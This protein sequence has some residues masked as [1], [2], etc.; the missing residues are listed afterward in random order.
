MKPQHLTAKPGEVAEKVLAVGDPARAKMVAEKYLEEAKLVSSNRELLVYTGKYNG[1]EVSVAVHGI[2]G[3]SA[4]IVFEE[5]RMLGA[6]LIVR[7]GTAGSLRKEIGVPEPIVVTGAS[8]YEGGVLG[9]YSPNTCLSTSPDP[10]L[11]SHIAKTFSQRNVNYHLGPVISNDAFYAES[12]NFAEYWAKRGMVA[13]E[14][15]C[16]TLFALGWMRGFKTG[17]VV[18]TADSLVDPSKKDLL[19]HEQLAPVMEKVTEALLD[20]ISTF[21]L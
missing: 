9:V 1:E 8:Y 11:T 12:E 6:K 15:E 5:L 2:G 7:L 17:A 21:S 14:M 19:H 3:P 18:V 20:A 10:I 4:A 16:A 13:V